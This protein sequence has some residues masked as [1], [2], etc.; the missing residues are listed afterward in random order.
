MFQS[1][2]KKAISDQV[3]EQIRDQILLGNLQKGE[4]LPSERKLCTLFAVNRGAIREAI[5]KL[6]QLKL[7]YVQQGGST[8]VLEYHQTASIDLLPH[9]LFL[10]QHM[11]QDVA[12]SILELRLALGK[13]IVKLCALRM[14]KSNIKILEDLVDQMLSTE[15]SN[16]REAYSMQFWQVLVKGSDNIAYQLA[17]NTLNQTFSIMRTA[18]QEHLSHEWNNVAGYQNLAHYIKISATQRAE[19]CVA[20]LLIHSLSN[21][22]K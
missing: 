10:D 8:K 15:D 4:A 12:Q 3:Y 16:Q 11:N 7:V 5:K 21:S 17:F 14:N 20:D 18:F 2:Q 6:E 22:T 13:D 9:L 1:I 19:E